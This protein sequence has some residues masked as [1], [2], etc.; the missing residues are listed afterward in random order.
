MS[1]LWREQSRLWTHGSNDLHSPFAYTCLLAQGCRLK[2]P[3][4]LYRY[5]KKHKTIHMRR[6]IR[7]RPNPPSEETYWRQKARTIKQES[8]AQ[9]WV[10]STT[11]TP[12]RKT[13]ETKPQIWISMRSFILNSAGPWTRGHET[14][15]D[16]TTASDRNVC[17]LKQPRHRA[18]LLILNSTIHQL[19][20]SDYR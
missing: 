12:K 15:H 10:R 4:R 18:R 11:G 14:K 3:C 13:T 5:Q 6:Y 8:V 9:I 1:T 7:G 20:D 19:R 16:A 2:K 17:F